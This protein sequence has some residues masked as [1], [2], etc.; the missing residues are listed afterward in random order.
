M[1]TKW[2]LKREVK[3]FLEENNLLIPTGADII[4]VRYA[5]ITTEFRRKFIKN[6]SDTPQWWHKN[7][8]RNAIKDLGYDLNTTNDSH[9]YLVCDKDAFK[10]CKLNVYIGDRGKYFQIINIRKSD[11][12]KY[13]SKIE[14]VNDMAINEKANDLFRICYEKISGIPRNSQIFYSRNDYH[15]I[16]AIECA[17]I[18]ADEAILIAPW[19][20]KQELSKWEGIKLEISKFG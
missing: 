6:G 17:M 3:I 2:D 20:S 16:A 15:V 4:M 5:N 8:I 14:N 12:K 10:K 9:F 19:K 13:I 18:I 11:S 7:D 1:N